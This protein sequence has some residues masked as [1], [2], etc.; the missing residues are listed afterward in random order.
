MRDVVAYKGITTTLY[1]NK[2][3]YLIDICMHLLKKPGNE[4]YNLVQRHC[5]AEQIPNG[6]YSCSS[7]IGIL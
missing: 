3:P 1:H 4:S 5:S 2:V 7:A 6:T